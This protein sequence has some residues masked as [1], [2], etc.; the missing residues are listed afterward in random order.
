VDFAQKRLVSQWDAAGR[1]GEELLSS[2]QS[3]AEKMG[4]ALKEQAGLF[5]GV[6][7]ETGKKIERALQAALDEL[8]K[9]D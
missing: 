7:T 2:V 8:R 6:I 5:T 3:Y 9:K 4:G 1:P